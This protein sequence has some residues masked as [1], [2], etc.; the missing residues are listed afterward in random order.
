MSPGLDLHAVGTERAAGAPSPI[1][2]RLHDRS[3][4]SVAPVLRHL[5]R[6]I[7]PGAGRP[8][9]DGAQHPIRSLTRDIAFEPGAWTPA[10][11]AETA[12]RFDE[13]APEWDARFHP[14]RL[15]P[16]T[17][18]LARGDLLPAGI[19]LELGSGTGRAT[20]LVA[21]HFTTVVAVDLSFEMLVRSPAG[22]GPRVLADSARLPVATGSA[23]VAVLVNMFLFPAEVERVLAPAGALLWVST[24][25]ERTPIYLSPDEVAGALP[26]RWDGVTAEAGWGSWVTL[27]RG[28]A[29]SRDPSSLP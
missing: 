12:A 5:D 10:R 7:A 9:V 27:R 23:D 29:A 2:P 1:P 4:G 17:D 14:G 16:L 22:P 25:G 8:D 20:E 11:S 19:C 24:F 6:A 13:L 28:P 26:G 21:A 18:A 15:D 3:A